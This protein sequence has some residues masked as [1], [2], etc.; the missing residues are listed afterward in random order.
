[1]PGTVKPYLDPVLLSAMS[2]GVGLI[3]L[4]AFK[5]RVPWFVLEIV[6]ALAAFGNLIDQLAI[7]ILL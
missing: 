5:L 1:M 3:M 7:H 6:A 4:R 2:A